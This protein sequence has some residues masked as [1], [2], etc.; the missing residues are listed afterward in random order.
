MIHVLS[1]SPDNQIDAT[2]RRGRYG[3]AFSDRHPIDLAG[4]IDSRTV[5]RLKFRADVS[6]R[7]TQKTEIKISVSA[8]ARYKFAADAVVGIAFLLKCVAHID[9]AESCGPL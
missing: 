3:V 7:R 2:S 6:G 8:A 1:K 5:I 9:A 4:A